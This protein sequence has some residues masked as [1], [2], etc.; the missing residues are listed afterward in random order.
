MSAPY[1]TLKL[2]PWL[3]RVSGVKKWI[4]ILATD[5]PD[6]VLGTT[7]DFYDRTQAYAPGSVVQVL[8]KM[9]VN[10]VTVVPGTYVLRTGMSTD[11]NAVGNQLPQFP[12][13]AGQ[14]YWICLSLGIKMMTVCQGTNKNQF[15][16][17]SDPF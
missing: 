5:A 12:Y 9:V 13:P 1:P 7:A 8:N 17:A 2:F 10:S 6:P 14:V 16:N 11:A 4:A 15:I 3:V